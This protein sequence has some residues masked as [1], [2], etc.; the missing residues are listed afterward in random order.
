MLPIYNP[1]EGEMANLSQMWKETFPSDDDEERL[2]VD[3]KERSQ[4]LTQ[5]V[6]GRKSFQEVKREQVALECKIEEVK[7]LL[8]TGS[9]AS[10][11][12]ARDEK[13]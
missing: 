5:P 4:E 2:K 10:R 9:G 6:D 13:V 1:F 8:E 11:V 3:E 7:K 12:W